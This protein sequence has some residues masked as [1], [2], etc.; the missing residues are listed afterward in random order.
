VLIFEDE[1]GFTKHPR[2]SRVWARKGEPFRVPTRSEHRQRLNVFGWVDPQGGHHGMV[3]V[4]QGNTAGFIELLRKLRPRWPG[5]IIHLW[6]DGAPWHKGPLLRDYLDAHREIRLQYLPPY[7]PRL[8][9]QERIWKQIRYERTNNHW[10][11]DL[12]GTW[13]AIRE[14]S[15]RW[16]LAKIKRLCNIT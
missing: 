13:T 8:N 15:R 7:Q 6:V 5:K 10:F 3:R 9:P 4:A 14:T 11:S 1:T 2:V 16:S 12:N